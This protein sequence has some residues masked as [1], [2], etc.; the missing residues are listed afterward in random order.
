MRIG[1]DARFWGYTGGFSRY[2]E[3]IITHLGQFDTHNQYIIIVRKRVGLPDLPPN[4]S[5]LIADIPWYSWQEQWRLPWILYRLRLD[6]VHFPH[7][8]IPILYWRPQ[9]VTIHDLIMIRWPSHKASLLPAWLWRLKFWAYQITLRVATRRARHIITPSQSTKDDLLDYLHLP[10]EKISVI[11]EASVWPRTEHYEPAAPQLLYVGNCYPHKNVG[12]LCQAY[13]QIAETNELVT[14]LLVIPDDYF[15]Q[16][17][18][19]EINL[20]PSAIRQRIHIDRAV[21]TERLQEYYQHSTL[22]IFSSQKEGFGLPGLEAMSCGLPVIAS[23]SSCLP[24]IYGSAAYYFSPAEPSS[25][26]S[27]LNVLLT[28]PDSRNKLRQAGFQQ[29]Q[30]YSWE[31]AAQQTQNLYLRR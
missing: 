1:I 9:I 8:N 4:F 11:S 25:L 21:S 18:L 26:V 6:I 24:E 12:L 14:L 3:Q 28:D 17:V 30:K 19:A 31:L 15:S 29:V 23:N 2:L 7:F 10:A 22:F 13:R 27:A 20:F 5:Y 16:R